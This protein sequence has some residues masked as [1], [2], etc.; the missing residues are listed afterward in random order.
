MRKVL[1]RRKGYALRN[2]PTA[3]HSAM[4]Q[5]LKTMVQ[6][7]V[8]DSESTVLLADYGDGRQ[9]KCSWYADLPISPGAV[10]AILATGDG[11]ASVITVRPDVRIFLEK[12]LYFNQIKNTCSH[13]IEVECF[14]L[15]PRTSMPAAFS[16]M[17]GI[18][19]QYL[20]DAF[21]NQAQISLTGA[22]T[23][24]YN[25]H[26]SNL[27]MTTFPKTFKIKRVLHKYLMPGEFCNVRHTVSDKVFSKRMF[28][29]SA[30][31]ATV[32]S[33]WDHHRSLPPI[34]LYRVQGAI[35]HDETSIPTAAQG[36]YNQTRVDTSAAVNPQIV[37]GGYAASFYTKKIFRQLTPP[38]ATTYLVAGT[39]S[40]VLPQAVGAVPG[41]AILATNEKTWEQRV[42]ADDAMDL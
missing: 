23:R 36:L 38:A 24:P 3:K 40:A 14:V 17:S 26:G 4:A 32:A 35:V 2:K 18:N 33:A 12:A 34:Y 27:F 37:P 31:T 8:W 1:G 41:A 21:T 16:D 25:E 28:G 29:L 11:Q 30:T 7:V 10:D 9:N 22:R 39:T 13:R 42:P 15:Y 6:P 19:P 5:A 20:Q